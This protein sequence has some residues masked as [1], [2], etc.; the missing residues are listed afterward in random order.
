MRNLSGPNS[1]RAILTLLPP[2]RCWAQSHLSLTFIFRTN[3]YAIW[4]TCVFLKASM[5]SWFWEAHYNRMAGHFGM[6]KTM[7]TLQKHFYWPKLCQ[8]VSKYNRSCTTFTIAKPTTK[9]QSLYTPFP[10]PDKPWES[11]SMDYLSALAST[12]QRNDY[13]FVM[14][15]RFLRWSS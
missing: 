12:K 15:D 14:V 3:C 5:Q 1:T 4:A 6:Q 13:V 7:E 11:I 2:T 10:T 8:D 9:K